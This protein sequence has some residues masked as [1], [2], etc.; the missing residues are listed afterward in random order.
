MRSFCCQLWNEKFLLKIV[1]LDVFAADCGMRNFSVNCGMRRFSCE[2]L[3]I[4]E[5]E[6]YAVK[7]G[8]MK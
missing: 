5:W 1:E 6:V 7:Y 3:W 8:M 4:V 2:S